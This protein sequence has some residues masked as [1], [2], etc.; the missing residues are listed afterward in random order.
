MKNTDYFVN[1]E[2]FCKENPDYTRNILKQ[3]ARILKDDLEKLINVCKHIKI[4]L[5]ALA[6]VPE[7]KD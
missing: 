3:H 1:H 2:K 6:E 5:G 7:S 4:E